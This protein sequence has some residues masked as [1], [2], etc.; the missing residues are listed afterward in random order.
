MRNV[1][2]LS[3]TE[4]SHHKKHEEHEVIR[5]VGYGIWDVVG[6]LPKRM[7]I[8]HLLISH[9]ISHYPHTP[10]LRAPRGPMLP[11]LNNLPVAVDD[12]HHHEGLF[13]VETIVILR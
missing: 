9:H 5:D 10:N 6:V 4:V 13:F 7:R 2:K 8:P 12:L 3:K 1:K 11:L